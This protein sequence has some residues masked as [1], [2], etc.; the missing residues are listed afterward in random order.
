MTYYGAFYKSAL[1]CL[2]TR[3]NAYLLRWVHNKYRRLRG[4][5]KAQ[6]HGSGSPKGILGSSPT[7]PGSTCPPP[8]DDQDHKSRVT[9]DCYARICGSRR[10]KPPPAT[11]HGLR[12]AF[13]HFHHLFSIELF[14]VLKQ[15]SHAL[16]SGNVFRNSRPARSIWN[17]QVTVPSTSDLAPRQIQKVILFTTA[18]TCTT[19][20]AGLVTDDGEEPAA[21]CVAAGE[22][23]VDLGEAGARRKCTSMGEYATPS[24][25]PYASRYSP[26][27]APA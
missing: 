5:T 3:I 9:G 17:S 15:V 12:R 16:F 11:R 2:L 26:A 22:G 27:Y 7:G 10:V 24:A 14:E 6:R 18:R 13:Q 25:F 4:R 20:I 1:Y 8:P 21:R 23:P 19:V